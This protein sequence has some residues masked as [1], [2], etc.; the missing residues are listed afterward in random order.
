MTETEA[1]ALAKQLMTA[2]RREHAG[3]RNALFLPRDHP[4]NF[5]TDMSDYWMVYFR[6]PDVLLNPR[7]DLDCFTVEVNCDTKKASL[8]WE[9]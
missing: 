9:L 3:V 6:F 2:E 4:L 1:I 5:G 7:I 8:I